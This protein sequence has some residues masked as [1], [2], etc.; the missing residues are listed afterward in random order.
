MKILI[1]SQQRTRSSFLLDVLCKHHNLTNYFEPYSD[2]LNAS[3]HQCLDKSPSNVFKKYLQ[4]S[5]E[6]TEKLK[7][8]DNFGTKL[9]AASCHNLFKFIGSSARNT[10]QML[11]SFPK[12]ENLALEKADLVDV[13][14]HYNLDMYD[15]IYILYRDEVERLASNFHAENH[16]NFLFHADKKGWREFYSPENKS[17]PH[18]YDWKIKAKLLESVVFKYNI[19]LLKRTYNNLTILD[20]KEVPN[21]VQQNYPNITSTHLETNFNYKNLKKYNEL[22]EIIR[23]CQEELKVDELLT[24]LLST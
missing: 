15:K 1:Y 10:Q 22:E 8:T 9:F 11:Y 13:R 14:K 4:K 24:T 16:D 23:K 5:H 6:V 18:L 2:I 7:N 20:Y 17:L 3:Y 12:S 19:E 21:Y